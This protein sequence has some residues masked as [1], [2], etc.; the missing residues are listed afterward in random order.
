MPKLNFS[1]DRNYW[2]IKYLYILSGVLKSD[3]KYYISN[4][5]SVLYSVHS[6][7]KKDD[8]SIL[9]VIAM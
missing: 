5:K 6:L 9:E 2:L 3:E 8:T 1:K 7:G 4:S